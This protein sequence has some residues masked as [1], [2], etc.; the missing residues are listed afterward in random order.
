MQLLTSHTATVSEAFLIDVEVKDVLKKMKLLCFEM[1]QH[2]SL[3]NCR[4]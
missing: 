2:T 3:L 4:T 1:A